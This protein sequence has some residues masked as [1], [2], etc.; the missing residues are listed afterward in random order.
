MIITN[1]S[2]LSK[3]NGRSIRSERFSFVI[4]VLAGDSVLSDAVLIFVVI[5]ILHILNCYGYLQPEQ[6]LIYV[7]FETQITNNPCV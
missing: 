5:F 6:V 3:G 1:S 7:T 2:F 4:C